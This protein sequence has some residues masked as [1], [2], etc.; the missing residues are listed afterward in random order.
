MIKRVVV[1]FN[2]Y[3]FGLFSVEKISRKEFIGYTGL[4]T[5]FVESFLGLVLKLAGV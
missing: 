3:G 2:K 1:H 5:P 4:M